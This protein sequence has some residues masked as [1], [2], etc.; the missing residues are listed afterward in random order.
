MITF[1]TYISLFVIRDI[2]P[3]PY[4]V[5]E[6][7]TRHISTHVDPLCTGILYISGDYGNFIYVGY[8]YNG[9]GFVTTY[10]DYKLNDYI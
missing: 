3:F 2:R 4:C 7:A 6:I 9:T 8:F 5:Q 10:L 1:D